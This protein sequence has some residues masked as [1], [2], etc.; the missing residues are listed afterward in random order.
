[1]F[2]IKFLFRLKDLELAKKVAE[3]LEKKVIRGNDKTLKADYVR[4]TFL[5]LFPN[6]LFSIGHND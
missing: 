1:M 5:N 6:L 3:E 4:L 2:L